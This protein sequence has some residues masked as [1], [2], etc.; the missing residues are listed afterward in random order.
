MTGNAWVVTHQDTI[1]SL[2]SGA[3]VLSS[4]SIPVFPGQL[5]T[6]PIGASAIAPVSG[7]VYVA[8][9]LAGVLVE[10]S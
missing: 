3:A 10:T 5:Q 9:S 6:T 2:S 7:H 4:G 8:T 1:W